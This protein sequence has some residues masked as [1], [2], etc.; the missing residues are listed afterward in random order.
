MPHY[1]VLAGAG[2]G[3]TRVLTTRIINLIHSA[4]AY[5]NQILAVT[6]TNKAANEMKERVRLHLG[7][8]TDSMSIGTFHSI[9]AKILRRHAGNLGY[10]SNFRIIDA[11]DQLR[12]A[13]QLLADF[14]LKAKEHNPR[15]LLYFIN[16]FKDKAVTWDKADTLP[17]ENF[18]NGKL[19]SIYTEYQA[20]LRTLN[21]MDFGDLILNVITLFNTNIDICKY[22]QNRFKYMLVDEYQD[23]NA[24]Q[25]LWLRLLAQNNNNIC[26][27]DDD[28]Q[29]IYGWRGAEISNILRFEEDFK[30]AK[31][32][33]LEKNYRSTC[34]ILNAASEL[35]SN[36][37]SRHK[38]T[39]WTEKNDGNKVRFSNFYNDR[40]EA[41]NIADEIDIAN[42][43][44]KKSF[45]I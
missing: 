43:L 1:W 19:V 42:R 12:L 11:D 20:R 27:V 26:C 21:A 8:A 34:H 44:H 29:S 3:K 30:G 14:Q 16:R 32:V 18:A 41:R 15:L 33:R 37:K 40:E 31:V 6:F 10:D 2:T 4:H 7:E 35:I 25:Y 45:L 9:S 38:K 23:T 22:Y 39:L 24:A 36:N 17:Q 28:D 13:K 5:P